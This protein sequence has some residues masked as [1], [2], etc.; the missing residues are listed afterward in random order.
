ML[1]VMCRGVSKSQRLF[2][3][4]ASAGQWVDQQFPCSSVHV[5][6]SKHVFAL[7]KQGGQLFRCMAHDPAFGCH[8]KKWKLVAEHILQC[9]AAA[10]G[11]VVAIQKLPKSGAASAGAAAGA[12]A[13]TP[14]AAAGTALVVFDLV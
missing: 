7:T 9:D 8:G 11:T 5:G 6:D 13:V 10:D 12:A 4:D 2:R 1:L 3:L 14:A